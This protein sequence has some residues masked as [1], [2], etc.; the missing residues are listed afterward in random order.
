MQSGGY[1]ELLFGETVDCYLGDAEGNELESEDP[2]QVI[3]FNVP[4]GLLR[5]TIL[6]YRVSYETQDDVK[7]ELA[8]PVKPRLQVMIH[9]QAPDSF[10]FSDYVLGLPVDS[11][12]DSAV[13]Q[14]P[15]W[16]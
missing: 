3:E 2:D 16:N 7:D 4:A 10:D 15:N 1:V 5:G 14:R 11:I 12:L 6:G 9:P 8:P 13:I